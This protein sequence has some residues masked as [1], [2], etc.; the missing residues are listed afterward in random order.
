VNLPSVVKVQEET[1]A[2]ATVPRQSHFRLSDVIQR[3]VKSLVTVLCI[4]C[5]LEA[6]TDTVLTKS[7]KYAI[8]KELAVRRIVVV[9]TSGVTVPVAFWGDQAKYCTLEVGQC[10]L[11]KDVEVSNFNGFSLSVLQRSGIMCFGSC[12]SVDKDV[13]AST[14]RHSKASRIVECRN[15]ND[16]FFL[17]ISKWWQNTGAAMYRE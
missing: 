8:Q 14:K 17:E 13:K 15:V 11:F 10:V 5:K 6:S 12:E 2:V 1:R 4:V 9:D 7:H 3:P 16:A